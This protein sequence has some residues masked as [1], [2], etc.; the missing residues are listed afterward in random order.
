MI[1]N[2]FSTYRDSVIIKDRIQ[3]RHILAGDYSY[4]AGYYHGKW[5]E[6]CV[7]YLDKHDD[8]CPDDKIDRLIIGKFCA[9]ATGVQ[10]M[11]GGNQGHNYNWIAAYPLDS[12]DDDFDGYLHTSPKAYALKGDTVIGNDVWIGAEALIMPGIQ[13]GDG[14]VIAARAVVAKNVGPY[15]IWG[16]NP[17]KLIKKRFSAEDID[18]L[19]QIQWWNWD[20]ATLKKNLNFL[21][22]ADV[23]G[24]W[25]Q[26]KGGSS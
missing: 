15:E 3:S 13:I 19:L 24:L 2:P 20:M 14:A 7:L 21:R 10:F 25:R 18:K 9:I 5:F 1:N 23:E 12:F 6:D 22:S 8:Y 4:Y 26:F 16:G 11:M 17:A